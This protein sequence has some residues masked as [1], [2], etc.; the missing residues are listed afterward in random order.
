MHPSGERAILQEILWGGGTGGALWPFQPRGCEYLR[1]LHLHSQPEFFFMRRGSALL[2]V[3]AEVYA[4][5][6]GSVAWIPPSVEHVVED[7]TPDA[8]FWVLLP[9]PE[10][11]ERALRCTDVEQQSGF[12]QLSWLA[13]LSEILPDPPVFEPRR[14]DF[15]AF[16]AHAEVAWRLYL[17]VRHGPAPDPRFEWIPAWSAERARLARALLFELCCEALRL[18]QRPTER[19]DKSDSRLARRAFNLL[20]KDP[21]LSREALCSRLGVSEGHLS[22][23]FPA[24]FGPK[25]VDQRARIRLIAFVALSKSRTSM[26]MLHASLHAGFGSYA[27]LHRM[28]ARHSACSPREYVHGGGDLRLA[29]LTRSESLSSA[30]IPGDE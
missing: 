20:L 6:R 4:M 28:F 22:R 24:M 15:E 11:L 18:T 12:S 5:E 17:D 21:M 29:K 19:A 26:N 3:G 7:L 23:Q 10:L 9:E 27:Q 2:R 13:R 16:E 14:Q 25:L 1:P 30:P 8:D